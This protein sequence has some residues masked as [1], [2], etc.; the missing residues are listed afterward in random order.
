MA[1]RN[2]ER[3]SVPFMLELEYESKIIT[4][5]HY[6]V[7]SKSGLSNATSKWTKFVERMATSVATV[8]KLEFAHLENRVST[9]GLSQKL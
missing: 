2:R 7:L 9:S 6:C 1:G 4:N 5:K 3:I 8:P